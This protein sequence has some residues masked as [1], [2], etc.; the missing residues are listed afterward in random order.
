MYN[1]RYHIASLVAVFLALSVG[2][3]LGSIVVERGTIDRQR[4]ALVT[5]LQK[6]FVGLNAEN[7][8]L[9][10]QVSADSEFLNALVPYV[11]AGSLT[12]RTVLVLVNEGRADGLSSAQDAISAAGGDSVVV[13]MQAEGFG[14]DRPEVSAA[15]AK[16]LGVAADD[17]RLLESVTASLAAEWSAPGP[18]PL[19]EAL[20]AVGVLGAEDLPK[21]SGVGGLVVLAAWEKKADVAALGVASAMLKSGV[22]AVGGEQLS[23]STGVAQAFAAA[24]LSA[25]NDLGSPRGEYSLARVLTGEVEGFFGVGTAPDAPFAPLPSEPPGANQ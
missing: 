8:A 17:A 4:E 19:T 15:A 25:V 5:S 6:E 9:K 13:L 2:L 24:G 12:D 3:V 1:I 16:V 21:D 11:I 7:K 10:A 18:R 22:V 20:S 23:S 14:L